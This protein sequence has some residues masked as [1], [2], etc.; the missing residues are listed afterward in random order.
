MQLFVFEIWSILYMVDCTTFPMTHRMYAKLTISQKLKVAQKKTHVL[1]N[2]FRAMRIFPENLAPFEQT[3][4]FFQQK[5]L[6][7]DIFANLI[8]P[9]T[10][11]AR[12]S[13]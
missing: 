13:I 9:L 1:K 8:E 2:Y 6:L 11:E 7:E 10:S 12:F 4:Y 3:F 5:S